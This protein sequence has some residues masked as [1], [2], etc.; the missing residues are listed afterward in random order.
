MTE[1]ELKEKLVDAIYTIVKR[2]PDFCPDYH[3]IAKN[4]ADTIMDIIKEYN[5]TAQKK[6]LDPLEIYNKEELTT[7]E[8][9]IDIPDEIKDAM[10]K[11]TQG[12]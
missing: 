10:S 1:I 5:N 12:L 6:E 3:Q 2:V 4:G 8:G 9:I 11:F 7:L